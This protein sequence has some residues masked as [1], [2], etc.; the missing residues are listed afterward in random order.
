MHQ[1][2]QRTRRKRKR[3]LGLG[4]LRGENKRG[5]SSRRSGGF[6]RNQADYFLI[7]GT[8]RRIGNLMK[9]RPE[10]KGKVA[11]RGGVWNSDRWGKAVR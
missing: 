3:G 1:E 4:G 2:S 5:V 7:N 11:G 9:V 10:K 8:G 6:Y